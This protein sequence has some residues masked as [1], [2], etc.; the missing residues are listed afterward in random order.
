VR[1]GEGDRPF[2]RLGPLGPTGD[3]GPL[4]RGERGASVRTG[5]G[6]LLRILRGAVGAET[7]EPQRTERQAGSIN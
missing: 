2:L 1:I 7:G 3:L 6:V 4:S 5:D